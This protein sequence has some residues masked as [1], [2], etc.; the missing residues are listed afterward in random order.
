PALTKHRLKRAK[1]LDRQLRL[2]EV[3]FLTGDVAEAERHCGRQRVDQDVGDADP[4]ERLAKLLLGRDAL[5]SHRSAPSR[6]PALR[7]SPRGK[8][9][10][11]TARSASRRHSAPESRGKTRRRSP[12][13]REAPTR[14]ALRAAALREWPHRGRS[15]GAL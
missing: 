4:R 10:P 11:R 8:L 3:T 14:P 1:R 7:R 5:L 13:R 15:R 2:R 6:V 12:R 9:P